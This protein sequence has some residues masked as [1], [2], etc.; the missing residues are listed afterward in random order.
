MSTT[1]I[2]ATL[3]PAS[4]SE[5]TVRSL[6]QAGADVFRINASHAR[7]GEI[8]ET[9]RL[10][11]R[12]AESVDAL[13]GVLLD[14]QGPKIRLGSFEN[15]GVE[16]A[17]GARFIL[18]TEPVPGNRER[19]STSYAGLAA[20]VQPGDRILLADGGVTLRAIDSDGVQVV[21]EVVSGGAISDRK[22]INLPGVQVSTPSLTKKDMADLRVALENGADLVAL[23]F[24]RRRDDILRLR[25]FLEEH[26]GNVPMIAKIEKPEGWRNLEEILDE[27]DGVMVARGD[28]GVEMALEK[29]PPI[30]KAIIQRARQHGKFVITA[31]QMLESMVE[32]PF[33]TRAEVSDVANAIYD[34]TDA[35]M[36]SA[37]TS[38]GRHAVEA[39]RMMARIASE[40]ESSIREKGFQPLPSAGEM[41]FPRIIAQAAYEAVQMARASAIVVFSVSGS[42]G[43]LVASYRPPVPIYVFTHTPEVARQLSVIYGVHPILAPQ[44][45]NTDEMLVQLDRLLCERNSLKPGDTVVLVAGQPVGRKGTTNLL[46]LHRVGEL[47]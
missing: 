30:Q 35:V 43:R 10:V 20:D 5:A 2:V 8:E 17:T 23:S 3:G 46:K 44:T 42:S 33:P 6:I 25:H 14:L 27:S 4:R 18:T 34:G 7:D 41:A 45:D 22:G 15:G 1:K 28:L 31:T 21:C 38:T 39:V 47:R 37:E 11:R 32:H 26:E 16:L 12:V 29:V 40:A 36:L 13:T 19:A 9:I 24:V